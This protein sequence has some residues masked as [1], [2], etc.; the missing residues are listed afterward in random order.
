MTALVL[1]G[2]KQL[3]YQILVRYLNLRLRYNYFWCLKKPAAILEFYFR[4][5]FWS[6]Y[7]H[8]Y[9]NFASVYQISSESDYLRHIY[10]II[11]ILQ[12][13]CGHKVANLLSISGLVP[14]LV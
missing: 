1:E 10:D 2:L 4:F 13:G 11:L 14:A 7:R 3:A 9:V 5:E 8:G 12:D 6:I